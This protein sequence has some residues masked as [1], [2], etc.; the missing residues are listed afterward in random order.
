[1]F[2]DDTCSEYEPFIDWYN[3]PVRY[4]VVDFESLSF[5]KVYSDTT[6][7][8][9]PTWLSW[10]DMLNNDAS[11]IVAERQRKKKHVQE[12][13]IDEKEGNTN[14]S[15][16]NQNKGNVMDW[17]LLIGADSHPVEDSKNDD[18]SSI[19]LPHEKAELNEKDKETDLLDDLMKEDVPLST[20]QAS[21]SVRSL[22]EG[23]MNSL[24]Q[25]N[26]ADLIKSKL[27]KE[28]AKQIQN[29]PTR[30]L[31]TN[32][33]VYFDECD[34]DSSVASSCCRNQGLEVNLKQNKI[35]NEDQ[36]ESAESKVFEANSNYKAEWEKAK[37]SISL[38][39]ALSERVSDAKEK[40]KKIED[41]VAWKQKMLNR[42][43][44]RFA[45]L[46]N[47]STEKD[48]GGKAEDSVSSL[49]EAFR[50]VTFFE[51]STPTEQNAKK[52]SELQESPV[53]KETE[54][55]QQKHHLSSG[56]ASNDLHSSFSVQ[57]SSSD[58]LSHSSNSI[59][60]D[61]HLSIIPSFP[62]LSYSIHINSPSSLSFDAII[63]TFRSSIYFVSSNAPSK[64]VH[65][66]ESS[67]DFS[68]S[69]TPSSLS[70]FQQISFPASSVAPTSSSELF[71]SKQL[72]NPFD[73]SSTSS[74]FPLQS[75][76]LDSSISQSASYS[77]ADI[78]VPSFLR[79]DNFDG[80]LSDAKE[81]ATLHNQIVSFVPIAISTCGELPFP[82]TDI[83]NSESPETEAISSTDSKQNE[84]KKRSELMFLFSLDESPQLTVLLSL[85]RQTR[86]AVI[87]S[88]CEIEEKFTSISFPST[89]QMSLRMILTSTLD[90]QF[91]LSQRCDSHVSDELTEKV[92]LPLTE[93]G[94]RIRL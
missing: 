68:S 87:N 11:L 20:S 70:S 28:L 71:S 8:V 53:G 59:L 14:Y 52:K 94:P 51:P 33:R 27:R 72:I 90:V 10:Q 18:A 75:S 78:P 74:A 54:R 38:I 85:L 83:S 31:E 29:D 46:S 13:S 88:L 23:G 81:S 80:F 36:T 25:Q 24:K 67:S 57:N 4:C 82:S 84:G 44:E 49:C 69:S 63:G 62:M 15:C 73:F 56:D 77:F 1:M 58:N 39:T 16:E 61:T 91:L 76:T 89:N 45:A 22:K 17:E 43:L 79:N 12:K 7:I 30:F 50:L 32:V 37:G 19:N 55:K 40:L 65:Q 41:S 92:S 47:D 64:L 48:K 60:R 26:E 93:I 34:F 3:S 6:L 66:I 5:L 35:A 2:D 9:E 21:H 86:T 42:Q